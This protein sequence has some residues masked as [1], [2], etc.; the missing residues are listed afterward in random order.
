MP[1]IDLLQIILIIFV[2]LVPTHE[3]QTIIIN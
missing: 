2:K 1:N 3:R